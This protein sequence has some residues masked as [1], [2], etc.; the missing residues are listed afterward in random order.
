[1]LF[2][3]LI[4]YIRPLEEVEAHLDAH[5]AFL[6]QHYAEGRFLLSGRQVP[7]VGGVILAR[8]E[9]REEIEA[10]ARQ[11]PFHQTGVADFRLIA[12]Q[13]SLKA[14]DVPDDWLA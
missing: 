6:A 12:W 2:V 9:S 7:R 1:M 13:P 11:D 3:L 10:I 14:E 4:D 8:G 5:R